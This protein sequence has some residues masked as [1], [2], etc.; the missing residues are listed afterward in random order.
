MELLATYFD[1]VPIIHQIPKFCITNSSFFAK[2]FYTTWVRSVAY[3][4]ELSGPKLMGVLARGAC[5]NFVV[6]KTSWTWRVAYQEKTFRTKT[7]GGID[8][9]STGSR[10]SFDPP[11]LEVG[12]QAMLF[13]PP[14]FPCVN[15]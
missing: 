2:H 4:K 9:E 7:A 15:T 10:G 8:R 13:D 11:L 14:L 12:G 6:K 5:K 1:P 3:Q